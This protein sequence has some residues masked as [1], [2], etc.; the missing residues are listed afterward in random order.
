MSFKSTC[1]FDVTYF[2]YDQ[3]RC[4]MSFGSLT[5]DKTLMDVETEEMNVRQGKD[6]DEENGDDKTF[7]T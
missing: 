6:K 1:N 3:H 4:D 2:P 5:L 7:G